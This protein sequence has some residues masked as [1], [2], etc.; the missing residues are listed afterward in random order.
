M[1]KGNRDKS[2]RQRRA[3]RAQQKLKDEGM[4]IVIDG[5]LYLV[6][7]GPPSRPASAEMDGGLQGSN[8]AVSCGSNLSVWIPLHLSEFSFQPWSVLRV[9]GSY[10]ES[11]LHVQ[12][13]RK[14]VSVEENWPGGKYSCFLIF[15]KYCWSESRAAQWLY[16]VIFFI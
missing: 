13:I 3:K 10:W 14:T 1:A 15:I 2:P 16:I 8:R 5:L 12:N 11:A 6:Q 7:V 9:T 4:R